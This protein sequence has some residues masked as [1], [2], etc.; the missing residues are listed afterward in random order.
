MWSIRDPD[1]VLAAVL[2]MS[3]P[4]CFWPAFVKITIIIKEI[5]MPDFKTRANMLTGA[6]LDMCAQSI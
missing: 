1:A 4:N 6:K 2:L 3:L 5:L